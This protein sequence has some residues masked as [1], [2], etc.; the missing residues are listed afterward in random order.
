MKFYFELL[1][2]PVVMVM[3]VRYRQ[4]NEYYRSYALTS[5]V[6]KHNKI[7]LWT[8]FLSCFGLSLVANFQETNVIVVHLTG[9]FLCFGLG[10][11]YIWLQVS[12][13]NMLFLCFIFTMGIKGTYNRETFCMV[14]ESY[15]KL[16][17]KLSLSIP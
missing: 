1:L 7:A 11:V 17:V 4:I 12:I 13:H 2:F 8:G 3:Y 5:A 10:T 14:H 16:K 9:A 15:K 6:V